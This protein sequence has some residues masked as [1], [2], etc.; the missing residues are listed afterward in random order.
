LRAT[1]TEGVSGNGIGCGLLKEF[2]HFSPHQVH[3]LVDLVWTTVFIGILQSV[4]KPLFT[5]QLYFMA[6]LTPHTLS[7]KLDDFILYK[8]RGKTCIRSIPDEV[9]QTEAT[10]KK[11]LVFGKAARMGRVIRKAMNHL[12]KNLDD[13][14][15]MNR[16]NGALVKCL[17]A[18]NPP[19]YTALI[20]FSFTETSTLAGR[21]KKFPELSFDDAG[22]A[23]L[24]F[25]L[26]REK[27]EFMVPASAVSVDLTFSAVCLDPENPDDSPQTWG[28]RFELTK[29]VLQ[30][31]QL[32]LPFTNTIGRLIV[33]GA[34]LRFYTDNKKDFP[35][36]KEEWVPTGIVVAS[37]V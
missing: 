21:L 17:N 33:V 11:A 4:T 6:S 8:F 37:F 31:E 30:P 18:E 24:S 1:H 36:L 20:G 2:L 9:K 29:G 12:F 32:E 26:L 22:T 19:D 7:G 13:K 35:V 14:G 27:M 25:P 3:Y 23:I 16:L 5:R 34:A 28:I 10:K 15:I